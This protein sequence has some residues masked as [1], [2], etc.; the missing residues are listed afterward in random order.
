MKNTLIQWCHSTVNPVMGC[1]GC[2]LW[3]RPGQII[4]KMVASAVSVGSSEPHAREIINAR[5]QGLDLS[6][7]CRQQRDLFPSL[8]SDLGGSP[9]LIKIFQQILEKAAVCYAARQHLVRAGRPGFA[10]EFE[11][12]KLFPRRTEFAAGWAPPNEEE[13]TAKP[14]LAGARRLIFISDMGDALSLTVDFEFLRQ[15]IITS[16]T[17]LKGRRHIWLWLSKRP[18][19]M[20]EF[21][22][23]LMTRGV[24]WPENLVPMTT[25]TSAATAGR[26]S[27]LAR[28]PA[29]VRGLSCEPMWGPLDLD[30]RGINWVIAGGGS[31]KLAPPFD[32]ERRFRLHQD[33]QRAGAAFFLKQLGRNPVYRNRPLALKDGHGG[34]WSEWDQSW[35]TREIPDAFLVKP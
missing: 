30:L 19:R 25:V 27:E 35:R 5:L 6:T 7:I 31:D 3:P 10:D 1:P 21:S 2:E 20:A 8:A 23:W 33:C 28:I 17:S 32:V 4:S 11:T 16:A 9:M 14:W 15:E 18:S 24:S 26:V 12:P 13:E 34:D 29:R 22:D